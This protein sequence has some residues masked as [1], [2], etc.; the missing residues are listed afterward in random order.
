MSRKD[1]L[2]L[3]V[4]AKK[5][6]LEADLLRARAAAQGK[7]SDAVDAIESKLKSLGESIGSGWDSVTEAT[8]KR[9]SDWLK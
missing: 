5:K 9:L 4:E 6:Q 8:A 1:E 2:M 3:R 7:K